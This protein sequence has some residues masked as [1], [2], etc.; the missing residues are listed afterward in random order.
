MEDRTG[1]I[2]P[3]DP[4]THRQR[5][6]DGDWFWGPAPELL[7]EQARTAALVEAYVEAA[8]LGWEA[9]SAAAGRIFKLAAECYV[10][11]PFTVEFGYQTSI[12]RGT[13]VNSGAT[14]LDTAPITIGERVLVGPGTQLLTSYHPLD[15]EGRRKQ[16]TRA[17][18]ITI[19]DDA[20]IGAGSII[21][22]GVTIGA[23]AVVGAGSVVTKDV[24]AFTL[25]VGN[26]ARVV[27]ELPNDEA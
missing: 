16:L 7:E 3:A 8:K 20:W 13:F 6:H 1:L 2:T 4:R 5:M 11:P 9:L 10:K 21:L 22:A 27:R 18:P 14:F 24:P 26:P 25:V 15:V 17:R 23:G 19:G 12:G